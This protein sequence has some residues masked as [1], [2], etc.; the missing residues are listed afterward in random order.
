MKKL[1]IAIIGY[2]QFGKFLARHLRPYAVIIPIEETTP[3][4]RVERAKIIIFAVPFKNL[5]T[6]ILRIKPF[7]N[8]SA[9]II[10]VTSI[11]QPALALLQK[12][13]PGHPILGTHPIF[14][15][16]SGKGGIKGL[17]I[18]LCNHSFSKKEYRMLKQWLQKTLHL[19]TI[20][21]TAAQHDAEMAYVQGLTHFIGRAITHMNIPTFGTNTASYQHLIELQQLIGSD[22]WDVFE[23]IQ[24]GNKMTA[25]VRKKFLTNLLTLEQNL[26]QKLKTK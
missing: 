8:S 24:N 12:Y 14:G 5:K 6:A 20:E 13:F 11:K 17:S 9:Y 23:T 18:V 26:S 16:Q 4:H 7:I 22:S 15:P 2:G 3:P 25:L 21:M 19:K 10:D 1:P